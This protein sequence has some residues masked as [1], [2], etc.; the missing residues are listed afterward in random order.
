MNWVRRLFLLLTTFG[1]LSGTA[2]AVENHG[3]VYGIPG[4][5]HFGVRTGG[6]PHS[7]SIAAR[8][9]LQVRDPITTPGGSSSVFRIAWKGSGKDI[10]PDWLLVSGA[11]DLQGDLGIHPS[12]KIDLQPE[13]DPLSKPPFTPPLSD[14]E[15]EAAADG[16]GSPSGVPEPDTMMLLGSGLLALAGIGRRITR[17]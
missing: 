9:Q 7:S 8:V 14:E 4:Q 17:T 16:D 1:L 15:I 11:M 12:M 5:H 6:E 10:W 2:Q 13:G 3:P